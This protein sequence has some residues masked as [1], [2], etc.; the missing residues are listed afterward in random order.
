MT[1]F[2][3]TGFAGGSISY[4]R[5]DEEDGGGLFVSINTEDGV[6]G[7]N[8]ENGMP[9]VEV[10][11]NDATIY[12]PKHPVTVEQIGRKLEAEIVKRETQ[13]QRM[14]LAV[15]DDS[16]SEF[17]REDGR[18]TGEYVRPDEDVRAAHAALSDDESD[19]LYEQFTGD[20]YEEHDMLT[21]EI[22][23]LEVALGI[24]SGADA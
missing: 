15:D 21:G 9:R 24:L 2:R 4:G 19:R 10:Y 20:D 7:T 16:W 18:Y 23:G 22:Q 17:V 14:R 5:Y 11:L 3:R 6:P 1:D 13:K 8:D 12:D